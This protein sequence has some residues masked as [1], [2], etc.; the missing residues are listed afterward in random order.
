[1][2]V[3]QKSGGCVHGRLCLQR[4]CTQQLGVCRWL[5]GGC[6][7]LVGELL[8]DR[9]SPSFPLLSLE[10]VDLDLLQLGAKTLGGGLCRLEL[11]RCR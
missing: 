11:R 2:K 6:E 8:D 9:Q 4:L 1:M 7:V 5:G 10:Q 3:G